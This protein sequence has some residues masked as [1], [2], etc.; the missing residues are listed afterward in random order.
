M[1]EYDQNK[2]DL[3]NF[4]HWRCANDCEREAWGQRKLDDQE[5]R[6]L[7]QQLKASG[8]LKNQSQKQNVGD[9]ERTGLN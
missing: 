9:L 1:F 8:W 6:D 4:T 5:A 7:F 3:L 2:T